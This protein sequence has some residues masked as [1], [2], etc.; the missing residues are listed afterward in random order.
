MLFGFGAAANRGNVCG[1]GSSE[2]GCDAVQR[3]G[4][5]GAANLL[6]AVRVRPCM[7][8]G[9]HARCGV[10]LCAAAKTAGSALA[11]IMQRRDEMI[12]GITLH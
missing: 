8:N 5:L 7:G 12:L 11:K 1:A 3:M 4:E 2:S 9:D 10:E 6:G